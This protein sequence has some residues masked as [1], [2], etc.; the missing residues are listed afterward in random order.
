MNARNIAAMAMVAMIFSGCL[1]TGSPSR[2]Q[3]TALGAGIGAGLGAILGHNFGGGGND[4]AL[5]A[6][7]GA[8]L[9]GALANQYA[10]QRELEQQ[11]QHVQQQQFYTTV[12]IQ[13]SNGSRTPVTLRQVEGGQYIGPRG[14]Y[15][16]AMPTEEQLRK[17]YGF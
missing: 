12:W 6:A 15:Y 13:N 14:E 9:G 17:V 7:A 16:S 4:R 2:D 10:R 11:I 8:L 5:G 3:A 1:T